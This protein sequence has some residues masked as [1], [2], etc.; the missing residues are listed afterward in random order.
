[1]RGHVGEAV[2]QIEVDPG[3]LEAYSRD[4]VE[5][6][7]VEEASSLI[8]KVER[9]PDF[10]WAGHRFARNPDHGTWEKSLTGS[11]LQQLMQG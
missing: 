7:L 6:R 9:T 2:F 3:H 10:D 5:D 4:S 1:M 8:H 11:E